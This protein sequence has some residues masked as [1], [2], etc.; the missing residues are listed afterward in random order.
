MVADIVSVLL[1]EEM[2]I[3]IISQLVDG[4]EWN[5]EMKKVYSLIKRKIILISC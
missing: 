2:A 5:P 1:T 3:E 4:V